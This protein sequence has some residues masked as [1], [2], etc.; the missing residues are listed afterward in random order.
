MEPL[1]WREPVVE[2]WPVEPYVLCIGI[3][4]GLCNQLS[5]GVEN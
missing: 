4:L 5:I 2:K 1:V 3:G